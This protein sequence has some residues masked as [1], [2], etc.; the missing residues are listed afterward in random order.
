MLFGIKC[1]K[2]MCFRTVTTAWSPPPCKA[3][4]AP[5]HYGGAVMRKKIGKI[6][7]NSVT[8]VV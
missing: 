5:L 4:A 1:R 3:D 2:A 7:I 6:C 8:P